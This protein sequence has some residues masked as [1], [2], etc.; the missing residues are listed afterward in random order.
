[1]IF[2]HLQGYAICSKIILN[3]TELV[4]RRVLNLAGTARKVLFCIK[5]SRA[6]KILSAVAPTI[7]DFSR[8]WQALDVISSGGFLKFGQKWPGAVTFQKLTQYVLVELRGNFVFPRR[9]YISEKVEGRLV[10]LLR[11][12]PLSHLVFACSFHQMSIP[13]RVSHLLVLC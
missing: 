4:R 8:L 1:M 11:H 13:L 7:C 9:G 10:V 3:L 12:F 2:I 6:P 5:M